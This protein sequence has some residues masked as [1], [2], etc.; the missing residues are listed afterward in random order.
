MATASPI[1]IRQLGLQDYTEIFL[2]MKAFTDRRDNLT[3]DEI[4]FVEHNPVFTQGQAGKDEY[5]L[6]PGD[7]PVLK[8]D[9][10]YRGTWLIL[11]YLQRSL[12]VLNNKMRED[13]VITAMILQA[14]IMAVFTE[15]LCSNQFK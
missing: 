2:L 9:L 8:S 13:F 4:W 14:V 6:V 3:R 11:R 12:F 10:P 7:I 1:V 5:I 15:K